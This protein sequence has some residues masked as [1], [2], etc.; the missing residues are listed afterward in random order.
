MRITRVVLSF[1]SIGFVAGTFEQ[2]AGLGYAE[3]S[4]RAPA[5]A[6]AA[7]PLVPATAIVVPAVPVLVRESKAPANGD[8]AAPRPQAPR[9][10]SMIELGH[11]SAAE[12]VAAFTGAAEVATTS[13]AKPESEARTAEQ[14]A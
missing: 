6:T 4:Q 12:A 9:T 5:L 3:R 1:F 10:R 2:A 8:P 13:A 7:A 11:G 14:P